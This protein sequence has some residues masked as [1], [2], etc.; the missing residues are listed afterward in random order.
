MRQQKA[1]QRAALLQEKALKFQNPKISE[2]ISALT[3][4]GQTS[5]VNSQISTPR[6]TPLRMIERNRNTD[7]DEIDRLE[8]KI[9]ALETDIVIAK[10]IGEGRRLDKLEM[11][12]TNTSIPAL[13][14]NSLLDEEITTSPTKQ[15]Q[16][17]T[18][19]TDL[20]TSGKQTKQRDST[21]R[22]DELAILGDYPTRIFDNK[23]KVMKDVICEYAEY[24]KQLM[25]EINGMEVKSTDKNLQS[26]KMLDAQKSEEQSLPSENTL[27]Q[28]IQTLFE[29]I[30]TEIVVP[31][32][33]KQTLLAL[34]SQIRQ[35]IADRSQGVANKKGKMTARK[36]I[37]QQPS[38]IAVDTDDD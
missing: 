13:I 19:L 15:Q 3:L 20:M 35:L 34:F 23:S 36:R 6:L 7:K 32:A 28:T 24:E 8:S 4:T 14:D 11:S 38:V 33:K 17:T 2:A 30:D 26:N 21:I 22:D 27:D 37:V 31:H 25:R 10:Q 1:N 16:L 5:R 18:I 29:F 9:K 12:L